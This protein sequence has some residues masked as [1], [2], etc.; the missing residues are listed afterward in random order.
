MHPTGSIDVVE[1]HQHTTRRCGLDHTP[2]DIRRHFLAP[3]FIVR[4]VS[5]RYPDGVTKRRLGQSEPLA[6]V[7][8]IVHAQK[9]SLTDIFSQQPN[10]LRI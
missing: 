5:L 2:S 1:G 6:N 4:H 9:I 7:E 3:L 8:D 10:R